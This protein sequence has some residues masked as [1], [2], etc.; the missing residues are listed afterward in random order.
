MSG[1]DSLCPGLDSTWIRQL[2]GPR[3]RLA[4]CPARRNAA[5]SWF[6]A[7]AL[8]RRR[9]PRRAL[10]HD[11][12]DIGFAVGCENPAHGT[13]NPLAPAVTGFVA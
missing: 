2:K 13:R 10:A 3:V 4:Q 11:L 5:A 1:K 8:Q 12:A 6:Y 7:N 9:A